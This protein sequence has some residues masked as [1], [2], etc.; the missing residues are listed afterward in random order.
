MSKH[1]RHVL[2]VTLTSDLKCAGSE[3]G[4][5]HSYTA[6]VAAQALQIE[7]RLGQSAYPV[8]CSSVPGRQQMLKG[9]SESQ[10]LQPLLLHLQAI[11]YIGVRDS[12]HPEKIMLCQAMNSNLTSGIV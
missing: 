3:K 2:S 1:F 5:R 7:S 12:Q 8:L 6:R 9:L 10:P 11:F 4:C